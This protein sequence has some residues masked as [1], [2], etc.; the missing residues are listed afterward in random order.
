MDLKTDPIELLFNLKRQLTDY[1]L[2]QLAQWQGAKCRN[3]FYFYRRMV[4][5]KF[6]ET[7]WQRDVA[8]HLMK[9][10]QDLKAGER[11]VLVLQAPPQHGKTE[12]ITD[13]ISW[14][15]GQ[16]PDLRTIFASYSNDLGI[17]VNLTLQR[18]MDTKQFKIAFN[19]T[20]L[21]GDDTEGRWLRT[22]GI[23][24]YVDR[25]G[26]F[27]NTT[28]M[29]QINGQGLDL[30]IV[31]DPIKGRA[32]ASSKSMRDKTWSW[33]TDDFFGRFSNNA[34]FIMIMT[35]WHVDDPVGRWIE[36]FPNTKIL[37]YPAIAT[38]DE[39]YRSEGEALFP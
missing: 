36:H 3:N 13:F 21:S 6:I 11:P 7:W 32:E 19:K 15:A 4:R 10:W 24:E 26:S 28:V 33:F 25:A 38:E 5:P 17:R 14:C 22:T 35:R 23:I 27:R 16:D 1:E 8:K 31:D 18:L 34:G 39:R 30:G 12:Q 2:M 9:F 20:K 37:R 29:G